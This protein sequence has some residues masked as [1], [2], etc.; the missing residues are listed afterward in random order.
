VLNSR[1]PQWFIAVIISCLASLYLGLPLLQ[2]AESACIKCHTDE[3]QLQALYKPKKVI[4]E[5]GEG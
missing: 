3:K 1:K 5:E 4:T 2:A